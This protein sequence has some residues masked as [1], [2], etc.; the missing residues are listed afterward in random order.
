MASTSASE[1][2]SATISLAPECSRAERE[3]AGPQH[4]RAGHRDQARLDRAE[5]DAEPGGHLPEQHEHAVARPAALRAQQV[6]PA[7][8]V[9]RQLRE[10]DAL[11]APGAIDE[12]ERLAVAVGCE[13]LDDV[14]HEVEAFRNVPDEAGV[15]QATYPPSCSQRSR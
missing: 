8:G 13:R 10:G 3:V 9:D 15:R 12:R 11:D 5:H 4:L 2:R 14:A 6:R 7:G 1:A